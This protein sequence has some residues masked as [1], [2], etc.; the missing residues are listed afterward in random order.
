MRRKEKLWREEKRE[1]EDEEHREKEKF[2]EEEE[3]VKVCGSVLLLDRRRRRTREG[4]IGEVPCF[5][6]RAML[7]NLMIIFFYFFLIQIIILV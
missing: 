6:Y 5:I 7:C 3:S 4:A 1:L 2:G